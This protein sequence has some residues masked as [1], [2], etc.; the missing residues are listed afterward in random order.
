MPRR[1]IKFQ[2]GYNYHIFNRGIN[3]QKIFF[4]KE[5]YLH[6]IRL[7]KKYSK[8]FDISILAYCLMPNHFHLL[9]GITGEKD[10]SVCLSSLLNSYVKAINK[11]YN[12]KGALFSNRFKALHVDKDNYLIHLCRYI[13]LNPL[14]AKL[15]TD[16][17]DWQFSNYLEF[18]GKR[19]GSLFY[20]II[21]KNFK[22]T[23]KDYEEFVNDYIQS[24]PEGFEKYVFS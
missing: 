5:N 14:K 4:E 16:L 9:T 1:K 6:F 17:K 13:H 10:L 24:Y 7:L 3:K 8:E 15:V 2:K 18:I 20:P 21:L 23:H 12:R 19:K 22:L 11:S